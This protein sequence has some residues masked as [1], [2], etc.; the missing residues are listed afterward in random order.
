MPQIPPFNPAPGPLGPNP[1]STIVSPDYAFNKQENDL[2]AAW[3]E[4]AKQLGPVA[5]RRMNR[6][7]FYRARL[8][9]AVAL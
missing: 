4:L 2:F 9:K 8:K 1:Q 5:S 3:N 6:A 7:T